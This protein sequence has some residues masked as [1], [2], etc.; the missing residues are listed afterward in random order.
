MLARALYNN[1]RYFY[2]FLI[3]IVSVGITSFQ[4]IARQEDP[5]ITNMAAIITTAFPGASPSRVETL[6]SKPL[7]DEIRKIP[8][9]EELSSTSATGVSS[10]MIRLDETI[11]GEELERIWSEIRDAMGIAAAKFPEGVGAPV[12]D[13][14]RMQSYTSIVAISS[15]GEADVPLS[16]MARFAEEFAEHARNVPG[17]RLVELFGE[18]T[19]EIRVEVD[20]RALTSRGLSVQQ[21]AAALRGADPKASA[22]QTSGSG[23]AMLIEVAGELDSTARISDIIINT[24]SNGASTRVADI[25]RVYR[26][27]TT[28]PA[29]IVLT[30]G[31]QGLLMGVVMEDGLQVDGWSRT[32]R[33]FVSDYA[34]AA[35]AGISMEISYDQSTYTSERLAEVSINLAVGVALVIGVLMLTLGWRASLVVAVILPLCALM[36]ITLLDLMDMAIHQ[37]SVTGL[38]VALGLL[39]DGSIVMT[40]EVRKNLQAG[41]VPLDAIRRSV[42]RLRG[43]L[44]SS[45]VTTVL[46]FMPMV[47]LP[48]PSGDFLGS[49]ATSVVVM[50]SASLLLAMTLT[51]VLA[52]WLLPG[53]L[54]AERRRWWTQGVQSGRLGDWLVR[55]IDWSL[56]RPA[57]AVALALSLPVAGF[58]SFSTLTGQ[59]FPGTDRDQLYVQVTLPEGRS[60]YDS[61]ALAEEIDVRLRSEPLI[62]RVDWTIGESAPAFYYN[63]FRT[64][65]GRS[66]WAEALVLT[67]DA[68]QTDALIRELQ[69]ALD[70]EFPSAR[71]I[72]RGI[73][74]GPPVSAP[75]EVEIFGPNLEVLRALGE[76]FQRRLE[77]LPAVTHTNAT[78]SG[79]T[80]MLMFRLDEEKL[81]LAGLQLA[82][83]SATL[84]ASLRGQYAGELLEDTQRLPI[85]VR[86]AESAWSDAEQI[87]NLRIAVPA[88]E[89]VESGHLAAVALNTLGQFELE[90]ARSPISRNMGERTN[91]VQA[92]VERGVLPEE[93]LKQLQKSLENDPIELPQ[94]YRMVWGGDEDMRASVVE[95]VMAPMGLIAAAMLATIVLTFNSW[96]LAGVS[97]LVCVC[98][99]GLS[100]LC[101]AIFGYPFGLQALI[102]VI[103]SIGVSI[104]AAIII[105]TALQQNPAA[106]AGDRL[107]IRDVVM[108]SS[109]HIVSTTVTTFGGFLPLILEGSQFWP[110]FAMAIAGG[111]LLSTIVSLF[112]VPPLFLVLND[113][114]SPRTGEAETPA[115]S[116][117]LS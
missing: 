29:S 70:Q 22:G 74:Q 28:P 98:S 112:L 113:R 96:R 27:E 105:L 93:T 2:L 57:V 72:V 6:V 104:N 77:T 85:V 51:P 21:V 87:A 69:V 44:L 115:F 55:S 66:N 76:Q 62:R 33:E 20:E 78:L 47:I 95:Q 17:T 30:Q 108:A 89:G 31:R 32:F 79:G 49:I 42:K 40:D 65:Q 101:L 53:G 107:A 3:V 116:A 71:V 111:V 25:A 90:P 19:Q 63:M 23:M 117:M 100:L 15:A 13:D 80:P 41:A 86:L 43:P 18:P 16:L 73:D 4:S 54:R 35:P 56:H 38:V 60:I 14:D 48:G 99:T 109:R 114:E 61:R 52:A 11:E 1:P 83:V 94:G 39:V 8:G 34:A 88:R 91:E 24:S 50:L 64:R 59:F 68:K 82:D 81:R 46:A 10:L 9:V 7:E 97:L 45:T 26:A 92:Y 36:S 67:R 110:P 103:G 12:F 37:M 102:G 58:L 106:A 5:T 84:D 75:V